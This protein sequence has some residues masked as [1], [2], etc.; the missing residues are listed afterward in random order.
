MRETAIRRISG[1]HALVA[2]LELQGVHHLFGVPGHGAYP[3]YDAL[4]DFPSI[5]PVVGR[6]EQGSL[7]S[8]D[9]YARVTGDVAVAT[10]VPLAGVT[11]AMTGLWE[12]NGH[13]SRVL[14]LLEYDPIHAELLR[15]IVCDHRVARR[16]SDIAPVVHDLF[17]TLRDG[18]PGAAVLE[19]PNGVLHA[20]SVA[21]PADGYD[22]A[23][24]RSVDV[25]AVERAAEQLSRAQRPIICAG[26]TGWDERS[27]AAL[28]RLAERV[29]TPVLTNGPSKGAIADDHP[30]CLG[31]NWN[32]G[33]PAEAMLAEADVVLAIGPR[34]G[35][36]TGN[37][38]ESVLAGQ[39]IHLDWDATEQGP[40]V[41]ALSQIA[42]HV[43]TLLE[44]V[45]SLVK[46]REA[47]AWP[48]ADFERIRGASRANAERA[49][50][51]ALP[52]Y[53]QLRAALPRNAILFTDSLAGLWAAR[54][55]PA[56]APNSVVFPWFTGTLGHGVPAAVGASLAYPNRPIA[57]LAGDGAF[58]YNSQE[59]AT[60][61]A[62]R[63]KLI[64]I[65]ANDN[66]Y[67][68]ILF[69][70]TERFGRSIAHQLTNPDFVKLG[71]AYGMGAVRLDAPT[72]IDRAVRQALESDV[73]W[74][75]EVPLQLRPPRL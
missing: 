11:N 57:V 26:G 35:M 56:Y 51:W 49:I 1:A 71:E 54:L 36:A 13:G 75:V 58:L 67:G 66:T 52:F 62:G 47:D 37:R 24:K 18:R 27:S 7:F 42:G 10:S 55:F 4:N 63:R 41:S 70:M 23:P 44:A 65:I 2:A 3:I 17:R 69:N 72:D 22:A 12:I 39:L 73:S 28:T 16:V 29:R 32:V 9:G 14:Y 53:D 20:E 30:L 31:F 74:L 46:P 6:N 43:P 68:A 61:N 19:V 60:M 64:V 59:L 48:T 40:A 34:A 45:A 25:V 5:R 50:P 8:A 38:P 15:P 21:D 33:G